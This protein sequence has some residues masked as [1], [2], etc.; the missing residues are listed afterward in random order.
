MG[1]NSLWRVSHSDS[2]QLMYTTG[3][4]T[5]PDGTR[6][7]SALFEASVFRIK[8]REKIGMWRRGS[9]QRAFVTCT[10]TG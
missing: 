2:F 5:P 10:N 6:L 7:P 8:E 1:V 3:Q 9:P 4:L